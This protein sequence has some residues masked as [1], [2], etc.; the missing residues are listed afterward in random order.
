MNKEL[1]RKMVNLSFK[2][3]VE[4]MSILRKFLKQ[5]KPFKDHME[6]TQCDLYIKEMKIKDRKLYLHLEGQSPLRTE[7]VIVKGEIELGE[8]DL[9]LI[10]RLCIS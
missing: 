1:R 2:K 5:E 3:K 10:N 8:Q 6:E 4:I 7:A 9:E